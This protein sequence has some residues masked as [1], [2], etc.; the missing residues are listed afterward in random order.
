MKGVERFNNIVEAYKLAYKRCN[1][2]DVINV[3]YKKGFVYLTTL[4]PKGIEHVT[5]HRIGRFEEMAETLEERSINYRQP[6]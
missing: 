2:K 5:K 6:Q 3:E 1:N 4:C